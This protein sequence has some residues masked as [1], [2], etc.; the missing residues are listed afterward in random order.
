MEKFTIIIVEDVPLELRGTEGILR[1]E[2]PEA[3]VIGTAD[4]ELA[5]WEVFAKQQP[6]LVLLDLGLG[7]S[8]TVGIEIC[9][10]LKTNHKE[11][12]VLIFTGEILNER[13]W[14]D[15]LDAG[16]NG[17]ILKRANSLRVT[18]S[19]TR[20]KATSWYSTSPYLTESWN[21]SD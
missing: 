5:F 9:R 3:E 7:G 2:V 17:I 21:A 18:T 20:W 1:T 15:A 14:V 12:K 11:V 8:T 19:S 16:C 4:S 6:D 13:L 10:K